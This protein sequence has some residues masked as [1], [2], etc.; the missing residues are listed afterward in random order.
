MNESVID[1]RELFYHKIIYTQF[2]QLGTLAGEVLV[3][4]I[5][6]EVTSIQQTT[7]WYLEHVEENSCLTDL[8]FESWLLSVQGIV[9]ESWCPGWLN[10]HMKIKQAFVLWKLS[11]VHT[12][13]CGVGRRPRLL[14]LAPAHGRRARL[15]RV[16]HPF[17]FAPSSSDAGLPSPFSSFVALLLSFLCLP[18]SAAWRETH[19]LLY[20]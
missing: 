15:T 14:L 6:L 8:C 2:I 17:C 10:K 3:W 4:N 19:S 7:V 18:S 9:G 5:P 16:S 1:S 11:P 20:I 12:N 13:T